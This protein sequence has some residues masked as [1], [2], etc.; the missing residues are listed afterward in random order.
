MDKLN[1]SGERILITGHSGFKG[2]WL[3]QLL[4]SMDAEVFGF[5]INIQKSRFFVNQGIFS[6]SEQIDLINQIEI[7]K[8]IK[9]SKPTIIFHFAAQ[10]LVSNAAKEPYETWNT[11][12]LG[13]LNLLKGVSEAASCKKLVIASTDKVYANPGLAE[14]NDEM[15]QLGGQEHYSA[16]KVAMESLIKCEVSRINKNVEVSVVRS[17]NVVGGGDLNHS[18]LL[19][20]VAASIRQGI[21]MEIRSEHGIRPWLHVL[22]SLWGYL[23]IGNRTEHKS[24]QLNFWN[25]GPDSREHLTNKEI[26]K[27][28]QSKYPSF[29]FTTQTVRAYHETEILRLNSTKIRR[30][31]GWKPIFSTV[32]SIE[33]TLS[34][35]LSSLDVEKR[36]ELMVREYLD[37]RYSRN[38]EI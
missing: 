24:D 12:V 2:Q 29:S 36:T 25:V 20:G 33:E 5:D 26:L 6:K 21:S 34:W 15:S 14:G 7:A 22:D 35:Y 31:L 3:S 32:D 19:P 18:R 27:F 9:T 16:S 11:N 13:T 30:M 17:G 8:F 4:K 10:S 38:I 37:K 28:V 23:L 1:F